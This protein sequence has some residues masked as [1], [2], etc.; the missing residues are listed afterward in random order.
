MS[1]ER[2]AK[3]RRLQERPHLIESARVRVI[4]DMTM[5]ARTYQK[6][7][8][9]LHHGNITTAEREGVRMFWVPFLRQVEY[10]LRALDEEALR[11]QVRQ[12]ALDLLHAFLMIATRVWD[13]GLYVGSEALARCSDASLRGPFAPSRFGRLMNPGNAWFDL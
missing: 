11:P 6:L 2:C 8:T 10:S 9:N 5:I 7:V 3:A 4:D 13:D 12:V 1:Q